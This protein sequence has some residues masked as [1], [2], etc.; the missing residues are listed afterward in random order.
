[1]SK[2][3]DRFS[4]ALENQFK[5]GASEVIHISGGSKEKRLNAGKL[6]KSKLEKLKFNV[7]FERY[8]EFAHNVYIDIK[9]ERS[10]LKFKNRYKAIKKEVIQK[11]KQHNG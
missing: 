8:G 3:T 5:R 6:F 2:I 4:I 11:L 9:T 10:Y 1:M 7:S